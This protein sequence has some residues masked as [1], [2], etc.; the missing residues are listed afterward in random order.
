MNTTNLAIEL[1]DQTFQLLS[2]QAK[3]T[4]KTPAELAA[5]VVEIAYSGLPSNGADVS[6][7]RAEFERCFGS[8]DLGRPVGLDNQAIDADL[9]REYGTARPA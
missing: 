6:V 4:G 8:I 5:T 1:S 7:A 3:A 2:Q 9:G